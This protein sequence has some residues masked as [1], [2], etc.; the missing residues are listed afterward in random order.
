[1]FIWLNTFSWC[2]EQKKK[3]AW[4]IKKDWMRNS[5]RSSFLL[6]PAG[7]HLSQQLTLIHHHNQSDRELPLCSVSQNRY[8]LF[9][10][11]N[12]VLFLVSPI[13]IHDNHS[14]MSVKRTTDMT[15][16]N[17]YITNFP[18]I[19]LKQKQINNRLT[20]QDVFM[21]LLLHQGSEDVQ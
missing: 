2:T 9:I 10:M 19:T 16:S 8:A 4:E 18:V 3:T 17:I 1:M 13:L 7:L 11:A 5:I 12:N 6:Q 21:K 14:M 20:K 15:A